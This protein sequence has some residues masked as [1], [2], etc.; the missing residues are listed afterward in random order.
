M[1]PR[2]TSQSL[3]ML[4]NK[5]PRRR[6]R[7]WNVNHSSEAAYA[8]SQLLVRSLLDDPRTER[9]RRDNSGRAPV[10]AAKSGNKY[11]IICLLTNCRHHYYIVIIGEVVVIIILIPILLLFSLASVVRRAL[12][13]VYIW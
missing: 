1:Q 6:F 3:G 13:R 8:G 7:A 11:E 12:A 4:K 5:Y 10:D 9:H 2:V